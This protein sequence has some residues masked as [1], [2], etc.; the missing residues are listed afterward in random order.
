MY[1][2]VTFV[3]F[4]KTLKGALGT[5]GR[6]H[7]VNITLTYLTFVRDPCFV[8]LRTRINMMTEFAPRIMAYG[9]KF[10]KIRWNI[11]W[12][13]LMYVDRPFIAQYGVPETKCFTAAYLVIGGSRIS[14]MGTPT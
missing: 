9:P 8:A 2:N 11:G 10:A 7:W 4:E 14:Q 12:M 5:R 3:L 13:Y 6:D 1:K